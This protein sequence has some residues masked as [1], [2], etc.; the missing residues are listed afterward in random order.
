M[1]QRDV[2]TREE[3]E[4]ALRQLSD[5]DYDRLEKI[6]RL[7]AIGLHAVACARGRPSLKPSKGYS[8]EEA[9]GL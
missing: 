2:A 4:A 3:C 9:V 6:A 5:E 7:R 8:T 1:I